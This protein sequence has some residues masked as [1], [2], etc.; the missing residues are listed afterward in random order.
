MR[1]RSWANGKYPEVAKK[2]KQGKLPRQGQVSEEDSHKVTA[3]A[4]GVNSS[5]E[6]ASQILAPAVAAGRNP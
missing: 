6:I 4:A 5:G 3:A 2:I 1:L